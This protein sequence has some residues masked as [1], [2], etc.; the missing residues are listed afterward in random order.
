MVVKLLGGGRDLS[1]RG[2]TFVPPDGASFLLGLFKNISEATQ[3]LFPILDSQA[4]PYKEAL[5]WM[6][7]SYTADQVGDYVL[8][9]FK[10][11]VRS[12]VSERDP[13]FSLTLRHL[14]RSYPG[15]YATLPTSTTP[16]PSPGLITLII[17]QLVGRLSVGIVTQARRGEG[18]ITIT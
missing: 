18:C 10:S 8:P 17:L 3:T 13:L 16:S 2:L 6:Q 9:V 4:P 5:N 1:Y 14:R 15:A 11:P 12:M 7:F